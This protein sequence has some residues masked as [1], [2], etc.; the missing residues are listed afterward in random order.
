M[1]N[2]VIYIATG[3]KYVAEACQSVASLKRKMPNRSV[4]LFADQPVQS[5]HFN[6][7]ILITNPQYS[8]IDKIQHIDQSLY[9]NTLFLDTDTYICDVLDPLFSLLE[10]FDLAVAHA[11]LRRQSSRKIPS[12]FQGFNT[13]V[14]GFKKSPKFS[15]F[16]AKWLL[17]HQ[18][19]L[20]RA[21]SSRKNLTDQK[22]FREAVFLSDLRFVTLTP[23]YNCRFSFPGHLCGKVKILHGRHRDFEAFSQQI[24][25]QLESRFLI[26]KF[27]VL[28][29][30][31]SFFKT[32][33]RFH[34]ILKRITAG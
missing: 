18:K 15:Q 31:N 17:I 30:N 28:P 26:P 13:G 6:H 33:I 3:E 7:V 23:E 12:S 22:A 1:T 9:E 27:G 19:N 29:L 4:T 20:K 25:Q 11:P 14:I 16:A 10:T 32:L 24:N 34:T 2:G 8:Y 21:I 5:Q